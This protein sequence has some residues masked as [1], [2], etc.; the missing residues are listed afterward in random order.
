MIRL[1][2]ATMTR[3]CSHTELAGVSETWRKPELKEM[4]QTF[5]AFRT[6]ATN[7]NRTIA[8]ITTWLEIK[9]RT[10]TIKLGFFAIP[11]ADLRA[12]TSNVQERI[13][14]GELSSQI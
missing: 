7:L 5:R 8:R 1:K 9:M 11:Q 4:L 13:D 2:S 6:M 10:N 3:P 12:L 14:R